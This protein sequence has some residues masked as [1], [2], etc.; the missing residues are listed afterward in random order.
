MSEKLS[1]LIAK[2]KNKES[3]TEEECLDVLDKKEIQLLPLL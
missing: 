2:I 3:L 1:A